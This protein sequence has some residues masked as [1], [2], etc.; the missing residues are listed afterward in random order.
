MVALYRDVCTREPVLAGS[1]VPSRS[2]Q[3]R[4][5]DERRRVEVHVRDMGL[6]DVS[7]DQLAHKGTRLLRDVEHDLEVLRPLVIAAM[8]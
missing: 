8:P 5:Y 1:T 4:R 3:R 2:E 7:S 6:I